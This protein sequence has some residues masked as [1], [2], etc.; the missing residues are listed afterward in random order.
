MASNNDS[1]RLPRWRGAA[2]AWLV[3]CCA[4]VC[5]SDLG[6]LSVGPTRSGVEIENAYAVL[7][8]G[9]ALFVVFVWPLFDRPR[10]GGGG[11]LAGAFIR[12][13]A[14]LVLAVPFVLIA[15]RTQVVGVGTIVRSQALVLLL[16]FSAGVA[17][18]LP[19]AVSWYL[20]SVFGLSAVVP[21]TAY[22][23]LEEG[24][25]PPGW[26]EAV[27][28]LWAAGSAASGG[29]RWLPLVVFAGLG[30]ALTTVRMV[31]GRVGPNHA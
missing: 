3:T 30:V 17:I 19:D 23:L 25:V 28:P 26:G 6:L 7:V 10:R 21:F 12:L 18:R 20:P 24:G 2:I 15:A 16:G 22:L 8:V 11:G 9:Q 13:I 27:S 5:V 29:G 14:L 4:A 1:S 31:V